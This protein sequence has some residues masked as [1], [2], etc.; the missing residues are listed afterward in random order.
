MSQWEIYKILLENG[1]PM[2]STEVAERLGITRN[3]AQLCLRRMG[4]FNFVDIVRIRTPANRN[5]WYYKAIKEKVKSN[6]RK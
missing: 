4:R 1:K 3:S 5:L 2:T 6:G